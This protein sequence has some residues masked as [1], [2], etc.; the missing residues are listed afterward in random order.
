MLFPCQGCYLAFH[1][2]F[3][4]DQIEIFGMFVVDI[5]H[6]PGSH[7]QIHLFGRMNFYPT[8]DSKVWIKASLFSIDFLLLG[9]DD[10]DHIQ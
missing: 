2:V 4:H 3:T 9:G 5:L 7:Y 1:T 6:M 10:I 8:N